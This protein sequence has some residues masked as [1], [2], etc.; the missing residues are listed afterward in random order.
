MLDFSKQE[1]SFV[2]KINE[3]HQ[4][5]TELAR[6][7]R[8]WENEAATELKKKQTVECEVSRMKVDLEQLHMD[9]KN[10]ENHISE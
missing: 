7:L 2:A 6:E 5:N 9:N 10:L 1:V 8:E 3:L 4:E